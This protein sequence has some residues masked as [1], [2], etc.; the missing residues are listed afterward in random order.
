M[1]RYWSSPA[2]EEVRSRRDRAW[3][4]ATYRHE[5]D[6]TTTAPKERIKK[7]KFVCAFVIPVDHQ[8]AG[9]GGCTM[10]YDRLS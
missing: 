2:R 1:V 9:G 4:G 5:V 3:M 6:Q 10:I 8:D 7:T